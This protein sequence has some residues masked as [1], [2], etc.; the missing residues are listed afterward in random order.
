MDSTRLRGIGPLKLFPETF[1]HTF[2]NTGTEVGGD[3]GRFE[4]LQ[5]GWIRRAAKQSI[6]GPTNDIARFGE[7]VT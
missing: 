2:Y 7:S 1:H 3:E 5:K 4:L 6:Q